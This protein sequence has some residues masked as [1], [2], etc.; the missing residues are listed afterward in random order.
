MKSLKS[1]KY[2]LTSVPRLAEGVLSR[3]TADGTIVV[4][5]LDDQ[6]YFFQINGIASQI[7]AAI[8]GKRSLDGILRRIAKELKIEP[9]QIEAQTLSF[10]KDLSKEK[11]IA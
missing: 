5:R 9:G 7:W 1:K 10:M 8:D 3:K 11:L 4:M 2:D 6:G